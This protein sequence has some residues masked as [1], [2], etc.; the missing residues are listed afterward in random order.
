MDGHNPHRLAAI[1]PDRVL[2]AGSFQPNGASDPLVANFRGRSNGG[3]AFTV[4]RAGVGLYTVTLPAG[5][6][7]PNQPISI[8]VTKQSAVL[9]TDWFDAFV[10]GETNLSAT[11]RTFQ[12]QAH[13]AGTA[14]EVPATAG[15]RVNFAIV[16]NNNTGG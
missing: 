5:F 16:V 7:M 6:R 9:A 11:G 4:T 1:G 3:M 15:N 12:I 14:F 8:H 13:R 10:V 2:L